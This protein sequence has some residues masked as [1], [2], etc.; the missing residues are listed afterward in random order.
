MK[1]FDAKHIKN[2]LL[3]GSH[4]CVKT[5]LCETMP[6]KAGLINRRGR[7]EGKNTVSDFHDSEQ[8]RVSGSRAT[9]LHTERRNGKI[10]I[11]ETR[12]PMT[13]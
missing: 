13:L 11:I 5:A 4:G 9:C 12:G 1:I 10:N 6:F 8:D 3:R 2:I 7:V